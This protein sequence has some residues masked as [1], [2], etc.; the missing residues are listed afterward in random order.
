MRTSLVALVLWCLIVIAQANTPDADG[1]DSSANLLL[2]E[3]GLGAG[4]PGYQ[5]YSGTIAFQREQ[6][7]VALRA[8]WTA[9]GPFL[10]VAGRYYLPV[11]FLPTFASAGIGIFGTA[12]VLSVTVGLH[13]PLGIGSPWRI[14]LEGGAA[15]TILLGERRILPTV[16]ATVGYTFFIDQSPVIDQSPL[17][18]ERYEREGYERRREAESALAGCLEHRPPDSS[19]LGQSIAAAIE[20]ETAHARVVFPG[21]AISGLSYSYDTS[22]DRNTAYLRGSWSAT[23]TTP[24]GSSSPSSG[25]FEARFIWTG[26]SWHL[27][28]YSVLPG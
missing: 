27:A 22:I 3:L 21:Y 16:S 8:S 2:A 25:T 12:P 4:W 24:S 10:A 9:V 5:L 11:D 1:A 6:F 17:T 7:G 13:V 20:R 26:C 19:T 18:A 15:M 23:I 14:T 28:D